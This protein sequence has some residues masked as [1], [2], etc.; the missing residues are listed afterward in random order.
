MCLLWLIVEGL[1]ACNLDWF[2]RPGMKLPCWRQRV[3]SM[4]DMRQIGAIC[5]GRPASEAFQAD[6]LLEGGTA[7]GNG[8]V[9]ERGL[10]YV[11]VVFLFK[12]PFFYP[13]FTLHTSREIG[14]DLSHVRGLVQGLHKSCSGFAEGSLANAGGRTRRSALHRCGS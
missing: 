1:L 12:V 11:T 3:R 4:A 13:Q 14:C 2:S 9:K 5:A 6:I 10:L 7:P 8:T